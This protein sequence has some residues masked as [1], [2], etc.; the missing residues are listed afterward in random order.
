MMRWHILGKAS[1][2]V[3]PTVRHRAATRMRSAGVQ[4]LTAIERSTAGTMHLA[5]P[6]GRRPKSHVGD[7]VRRCT[8]S[9]F[10]R[11][12][13]RWFYVDGDVG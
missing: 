1:G 4:T 3:N 11:E 6:S 8:Y 7:I 13:G 5:G 12:D 10:V 2:R 9:R